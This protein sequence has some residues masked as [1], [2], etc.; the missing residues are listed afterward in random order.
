MAQKARRVMDRACPCSTFFF[1]KKSLEVTFVNNC[2][3]KNEQHPFQ[4]YFLGNL[5]KFGQET[6]IRRACPSHGGKGEV[7]EE[8]FR[9]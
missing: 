3:L 6:D 1:A 2:L 7:S 4:K 8:V 9:P 5:T